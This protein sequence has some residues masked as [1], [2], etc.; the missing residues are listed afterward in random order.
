MAGLSAPH[1][2]GTLCREEGEGVSGRT[3]AKG[4]LIANLHFLRR[5]PRSPNSE[6][7]TPRPARPGPPPAPPQL[8]V[9]VVL[10]ETNCGIFLFP[11]LPSSVFQRAGTGGQ[12]VL[13]AAISHA[14]PPDPLVFPLSFR[15]PEPAA[16]AVFQG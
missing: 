4:S 16:V 6:Q 15:P 11:S 2:S 10:T 5:S 7:P 14:C 8:S 12:A 1:P 3:G 9:G 13:A